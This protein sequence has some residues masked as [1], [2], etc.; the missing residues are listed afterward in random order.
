[1][2]GIYAFLRQL[3]LDR[4][5]YP[6]SRT[7][8]DVASHPLGKLLTD[9]QP[10]TESLGAASAPVETL[11]NVR[12]IGRSYPGTLIF[13]DNDARLHTNLDVSAPVRVL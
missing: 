3:D 9:G 6:F 5:P 2:L 13:H 7:N 10:Q 12:K 8:G 1:M 4:C 11:E